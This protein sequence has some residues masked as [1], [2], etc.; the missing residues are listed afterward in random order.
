MLSEK[1]NFVNKTQKKLIQIIKEMSFENQ[2]A[3]LKYLE[4]DKSTDRRKYPRKQC[5]LEVNYATPKV[6]DSNFMK[7]ISEGGMFVKT[8]QKVAKGEDIIL[9]FSFPGKLYIIKAVGE[10]VRVESDGIGVKFQ[11]EMMKDINKITSFVN[12]L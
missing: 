7:D 2:L 5:F 8:D 1:K 10:V 11:D 4:K 3:L 6:C 9:T 12:T